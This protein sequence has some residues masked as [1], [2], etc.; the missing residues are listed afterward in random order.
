MVEKTESPI[1]IPNLL[2]DSLSN[3]YLLLSI[4]TIY[5]IFILSYTI[6]LSLLYNIYYILH[7]TTKPYDKYIFMSVYQLL[8][9]SYDYNNR[10]VISVFGLH[11]G[12]ILKL[13]LIELRLAI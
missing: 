8:L 9:I 5:Y 3:I 10:N 13:D 11:Y 4:S 6:L 1:L 12:P 2:T 7:V